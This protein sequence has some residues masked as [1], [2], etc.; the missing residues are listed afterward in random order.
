MRLK[1]SDIRI[2]DKLG[3]VPFYIA[4]C[5]EEIKKTSPHK[6]DNYY[7][8]V[9][10][11]EGEGFHWIETERYVIS[12]PEFYFLQP[13]Q[14][15]HWEFTSVPKGYVILFK[16]SYFDDL[17]DR[18]IITLILKLTSRFRTGL[19]PEYSPQSIFE[20]ILEEY[21]RN[22]EFSSKIIKGYLMAMLAKILQITNAEDDQK[23]VPDSLYKQ[24]QELVNIECPRLNKVKDFAKLL[25]TTPQNINAA[26]RKH[27]GV[28]AKELILNQLILESKRYL[29]HTENTLTEIAYR[30]QF[31][32]TSYFNKFFKKKV[33]LS[34]LQFRKNTF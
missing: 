14:L 25:N 22:H 3:N 31:N 1:D 24:Y 33:G 8:L 26:C 20:N 4:R 9:Y 23:Q 16:K 12:T 15:H 19:P 7:E 29:L 27:I 28:S 18:D 21:S 34:P 5:Y 10:L 17:Y 6:H 2:E 32:D 13:V 11:M 30:L